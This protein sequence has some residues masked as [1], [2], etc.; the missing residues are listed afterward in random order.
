MNAVIARH[1][2]FVAVLCLGFCHGFDHDRV[3][4]GKSHPLLLRHVS[5]DVA[6]LLER[7]VVYARIE[8]LEGIRID[9]ARRADYDVPHACFL[10]SLHDA[11][12]GVAVGIEGAGVHRRVPTVIHSVTES[13]DIGMEDEDVVFHAIQ[14]AR[15]AFPSPAKLLRLQA[16]RWLTKEQILLHIDRIDPLGRDGVSANGN[17]VLWLKHPCASRNRKGKSRGESSSCQ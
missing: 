2:V 4:V 13:H 7:V 14:V 5:S 9:C 8:L 6:E 3:D 16:R 11:R 1:I 10:Q 17:E 12:H 15:G